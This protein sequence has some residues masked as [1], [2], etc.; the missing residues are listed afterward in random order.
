M[1]SHEANEK[2]VRVGP[3]TP[4][5]ELMRRYWQPIAAVGELDAQPLKPVRL[6]GE[7]LVLY[8]D[9]SGTYGLLELHCAHRRADLSYGI[10]EAH[11]LRCNYHGWLYDE[12][13]QCIAQPFED[14]AHPELHFKERI[15]LQAYPVEAKSGL[16]WA[17]LGPSPAPLVPDWEPFSWEDG[18]VQL[19]FTEVPCNWFQ[20][21]E[22]SIDPVHFEWLHTYWSREMRGRDGPE[23]PTHLKV[24]FDEFEYGFHYRRILEGMTEDNPLWTIGRTCLWPNALMTGDHFEWRVP[25]DD[26]HMLSVGWFFDAV[27]PGHEFPGEK[28]IFH[29]RSPLTD[30]GTGRWIQ[31]HVMN[32]DFIAWVGQGQLADRTKEH[33]AASDAGIIMMRRKFEEQMEVVARGE[34]PKCTFRD[35]ATNQ[36]LPLPRAQQRGVPAIVE[37]RFPFLAGIPP[38]VEEIYRKVRATWNEPMVEPTRV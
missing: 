26:D 30:A 20:G 4:M 33:L 17:Y 6:M 7:D 35:P 11:G 29:W 23:P 16:L 15:K 5:G 25:I 18:L 13:G 12:S 22:N 8:K 31:S 34:D 1:A 14:L 32:Q 24:G 38:E 28:R 21:Q 27:A 2:F 37:P 10:V 9:H 19:V 3:G 36:R